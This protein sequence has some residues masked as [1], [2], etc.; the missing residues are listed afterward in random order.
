M[1]CWFWKHKNL[2]KI[3]TTLIN[4]ENLIEIPS[5]MGDMK[6]HRNTETNGTSWLTGDKIGSFCS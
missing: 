1:F 3:H 6:W 2:L 4:T 5:L